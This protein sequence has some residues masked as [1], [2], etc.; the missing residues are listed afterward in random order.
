MVI[1]VGEKHRDVSLPPIHG[2]VSRRPP[3]TYVFA[4][5][6]SL[7][8]WFHFITNSYF[9]RHENFTVSHRYVHLSIVNAMNLI[10]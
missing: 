10:K 7:A 6:R 1:Y 5:D 4:T 9:T 8:N 3:C 2:H